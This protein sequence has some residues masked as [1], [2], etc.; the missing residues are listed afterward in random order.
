MRLLT[1]LLIAL[2][3][4]FSSSKVNAQT[5]G[6]LQFEPLIEGNYYWNTAE[7]SITTGF[8][9]NL[10]VLDH[11]ALN[12]EFQLGY[13]ARYGF[14]MNTGWGQVFGGFLVSEF[15][16]NGLDEVFGTLTVISMLIPEGVTFAINPEDDLVFMPYLQPLEAHYMHSDQSYRCA[17]EVG[18]K[19]H[20]RLDNGMAIRPKI[21]LRYLYGLKRLGIEVGIG[22]V[23]FDSEEM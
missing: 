13:D 20:Y 10:W 5:E 17:G 3:I 19:L 15:G 22:M 18:L 4:S 23:L 1:T 6:S 8:G 14:T 12:V 21:G 9:L 7:W 16:G 11:L 2:F